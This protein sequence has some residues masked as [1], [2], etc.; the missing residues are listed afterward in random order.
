MTITV[1]QIQEAIEI[2]G[3]RFTRPRQVLVE[4]I[5]QRAQE[6]RDFT[7]ETLWHTVQKSAPWIGRSTVFRT[8]ELF[9]E[10]GFLDRITFADGTERYHVMMP[11]SH[12][13]HLTCEDC[14]RVV[15]IATCIPSDLLDHVAQETGFSLSDHRMELFGHCPQC[16]K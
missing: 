12:H 11:G 8:I 5:V 16:Q 3:L 4:Q 15:E 14:H 9:T 7:S 10:L 2:A 13:H 1:Q 6:N